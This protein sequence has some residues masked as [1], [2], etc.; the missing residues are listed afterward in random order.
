MR[1]GEEYMVKT[2]STFGDKD[3]YRPL[4][5]GRVVYVH[6]LFRF[7]VLEF[8]GVWASFRESYFPEQLTANN[9]VE[10][11]RSKKGGN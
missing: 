10:G 5:R 2:E 3:N 6:P 11:K 8:Q 9:R 1:I 4:I 7:A